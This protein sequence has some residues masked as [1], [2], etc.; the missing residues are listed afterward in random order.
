M[1]LIVRAMATMNRPGHQNSHGR[2]V[3]RVLVL[4]D[5]LAERRSRPLRT[6]RP[7]N[8]SAVSIRIAAEI[9]SVAVTMIVPT[10]LGRMCLRMIRRFGVPMRPRRLDVLLL[11]QRQEL[12]RG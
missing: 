9:S 2:V 6:P 7:R 3:E 4:D 12:G 5:Q 11:P 8:D 10:T 1:K